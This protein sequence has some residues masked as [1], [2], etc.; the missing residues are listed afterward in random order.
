MMHLT[1]IGLALLLCMSGGT[2]VFPDPPMGLDPVKFWEAVERDRVEIAVVVGD[3]Y[4]RPLLAELKRKSYDTSSLRIVMN[5]AAAMSAGTKQALGEALG[6]HVRITDAIGSSESGVLARAVRGGEAR[7]GVFHPSPSTGVV[8]AEVDRF[9][10]PSDG[11]VGWLAGYGRLPLGYLGDQAKTEATF[12][13]IAGRRCTVPGDR[14]KW[15]ED[16]TI[17]MLG[18]EATTINTGGEKVF[19]DEVERALASHPDVREALVVG[20]PSDRWGQ[21]VVALIILEPDRAFDRDSI[22][23]EAERHLARYKLPKDFVT[24]SAIERT[25]VGKPNYSWARQVAAAA[26]HD[27]PQAI[28]RTC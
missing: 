25:A 13:T 20:R 8:S 1:G 22:L 21:E 27:R 10:D 24:V 11:S 6:G 19:S 4:G 26:G 28:L 16:G 2:T 5:G 18:R 14:A 23:A 9:L 17:Q 3:A 12:P 15:L 7:P